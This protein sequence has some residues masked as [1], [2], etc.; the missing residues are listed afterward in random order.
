MLTVRDGTVRGFFSGITSNNR[1]VVIDDV[2]VEQNEDHGM[3]IGQNGR[4]SNCRAIQ[5]VGNGHFLRDFVNNAGTF[6]NGITI[7][8]NNVTAGNGGTGIFVSSATAARVSDNVSDNNA[9]RGISF[10]AG[11]AV[12]G[13][14][15]FDNG[16]GT[17]LFGS[18]VETG[19]NLCNG[20][21]T[22][23]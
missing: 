14:V 8:E 11:G 17:I 7:A 4:I 2:L 23:P 21:T 10:G 12:A 15:V 5:Y 3:R 13:N 1:G 19:V 6:P 9:G 22:C 18:A 16:T 20:S